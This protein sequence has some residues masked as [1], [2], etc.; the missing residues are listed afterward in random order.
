M[1]KVEEILERELKAEM[2]KVIAAN[3][4]TP[5]TLKSLKDGACLMKEFYELQENMSDDNSYGVDPMMNG[6]SARRGRN[7]INGQYMS[8][9]GE[10]SNGYSMGGS[11]DNR[12]FDRGYSGHSFRDRVV[13]NLEEMFDMAKNEHERQ[14]LDNMIRTLERSR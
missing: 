14:E 3:K 5:E 7:M 8:R 6:Y 2:D 1:K 12:S 11:Y 9:D 4:M 10:M 13:A